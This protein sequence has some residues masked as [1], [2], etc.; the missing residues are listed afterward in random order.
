MQHLAICDLLQTIFRVFPATPALIT[1]RWLIGELLCHVQE[2][3][4]WF[5]NALT[6]ILTCALT[7]LKLIVVH[8]PLKTG[9]WSSR[10]GHGICVV[11]WCLAVGL[12]I[13]ILVVKML[14][15]YPLQLL[16]L[17]L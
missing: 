6:M 12:L 15:L 2:I 17:R 9:A 7:T 1:D 4:K 16:G 8:N 11:L 5:G 10:F 3:I 14:Y 13:P